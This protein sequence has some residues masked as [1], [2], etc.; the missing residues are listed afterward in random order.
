MDNNYQLNAIEASRPS[1]RKF[2]KSFLG[3]NRTDYWF[4][5]TLTFKGKITDKIRAK[6]C[7]KRLLDNLEDFYPEMAAI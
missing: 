6:K 4:H 2:I 7:I 1:I 5:Q 3:L